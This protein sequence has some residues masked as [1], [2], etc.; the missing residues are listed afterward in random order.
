[1]AISSLVSKGFIPPF[2]D[3]YHAPET[4]TFMDGD[5]KKL[6]TQG[7]PKVGLRSSSLSQALISSNR[8][9]TLSML[10]S[11][12]VSAALEWGMWLIILAT[13][14]LSMG[15]SIKLGI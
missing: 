13:H 11:T 5:R 12:P 6:W 8:T 14:L 4:R 1:M 2:S 3:F 10:V 15:G 7:P 9:I